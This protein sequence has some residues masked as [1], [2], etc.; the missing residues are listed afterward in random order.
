MAGISFV[1]TTALGLYVRAHFGTSV[2]IEFFTAYVV[3]LSLSLDN[4]FI[5]YL[6][7]RYYKT[8]VNAQMRVLLLGWFVAVVLR[9]C[10]ILLV[11]A[12]VARYDEVMLA[13]SAL[14]LYQ[15]V[16]TI[17]EGTDD[18]LD[19]DLSDNRTVR[20]ARACAGG[21]IADEYRGGAFFVRTP[22]TPGS[23]GGRRWIATPLLL[24]L[25][26][27]ELSDVVFAV[28]SVPAVFGVTRNLFVAYSSNIMAVLLL[29]IGF[30]ALSHTVFELPGMN[31]T[32]GLILLFVAIKTGVNYWYEPD[33]DNEASL[34]V[35]MSL[36]VVG[37]GSGLLRASR[38]ARRGDRAED[39]AVPEVPD[40]PRT[41]PGGSIALPPS[42]A[43]ERK[44][45]DDES[46][47]STRRAVAV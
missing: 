24:V 39:G 13:F 12:G 38:A 32:V 2:S 5:F 27:C 41:P 37:I 9:G 10:M 36:L 22:G 29:R 30:L 23:E 1:V 46:K 34:A 31:I 8:P 45:V 17:C 6:I 7:F 15:A 25:L 4:M 28:D 11:G 20:V 26:T 21:R 40:R 19:A 14:L 44:V 35:I 42:A 18:A 33:W 47:E 43:A 16:A 3:E